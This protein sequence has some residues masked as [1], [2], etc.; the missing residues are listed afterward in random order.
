M[1]FLSQDFIWYT[2]QIQIP[3]QKILLYTHTTFPNVYK[4][5]KNYINSSEPAY[6]KKKCT[7]RTHTVRLFQNWTHDRTRTRTFKKTTL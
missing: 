7:D 2:Q 4:G 5:L 6:I 3:W 1:L